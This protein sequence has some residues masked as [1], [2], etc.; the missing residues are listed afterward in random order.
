M[1]VTDGVSGGR[2]ESGRRPLTLFFD[3]AWAEP[4]PDHLT[5]ISHVDA[6]HS[7]GR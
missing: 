3:R 6:L 5:K 4:L 1:E 7:M 2:D